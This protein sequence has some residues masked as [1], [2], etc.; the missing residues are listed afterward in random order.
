MASD[1]AQISFFSPDPDLNPLLRIHPRPDVPEWWWAA[2]IG[3]LLAGLAWS[4]FTDLFRGR[5][6]PNE[7]SHSLI[8]VGIVVPALLYSSWQWNYASAAILVAVFGLGFLLGGVGLGDVKLYLGLGLVLGP[9]AIAAVFLAQILAVAVA[10]P[11]ALVRRNRKLAVPM[12]PFIYLG[13][14]VLVSVLVGEWWLIGVGVVVLAGVIALGLLERRE[15][16]VRP[17]EAWAAPVLAGECAALRL[18]AGSAPLERRHGDEDWT[19]RPGSRRLTRGRLDLIIDRAVDHAGQEAL[20]R[21]GELAFTLTTPDGA[22]D[23]AVH[24]LVRGYQIDVR[25]STE[26]ARSGAGG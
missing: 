22:A 5:R 6:I 17:L 10:V 9:P 20:E 14:L 15:R 21:H 12:G 2:C 18:R 1:A 19:P 25:P 26:D 4:V 11:I 8:V 3:L 16:P 7:F 13:T 24:E 23:I